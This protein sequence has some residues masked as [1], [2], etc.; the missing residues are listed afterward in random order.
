MWHK[1]SVSD[2]P[3]QVAFIVTIAAAIGAFVAMLFTPRTGGQVRRG[4]VRRAGNTKSS[5]SGR[6]RRQVKEVI[7][8]AA[9][10]TDPLVTSTRGRTTAGSRRPAGGRRAAASRRTAPT[11][12]GQTTTAT[13]R[14]T[15]TP[16][17]R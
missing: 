3:G 12:S 17:Q 1:H 14:T 5:V 8:D 2:N 9:G 15:R 6:L 13:R 7:D 16:R 11:R 10:P 4:I